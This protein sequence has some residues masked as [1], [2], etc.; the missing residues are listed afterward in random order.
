MKDLVAGEVPGISVVYIFRNC[1][2]CLRCMASKG[3]K[4][5]MI[6]NGIILWICIVSENFQKILLK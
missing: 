3:D 6:L 5:K 2:K 1:I 4:N